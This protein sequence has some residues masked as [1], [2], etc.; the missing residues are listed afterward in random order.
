MGSVD[1]FIE[2]ALS[3]N[4][5][6]ETP[7]NRTMFGQWYGWNGVAWCHIFVS[8][9]AAHSGS[10]DLVPRTAGCEAGWSW[11]RAR[12]QFFRRGVKTPRKGDIVYYG[13]SGGD[14]VG[15]VYAVDGSHIYTIEGNTS[16]S[17]GFNPNGGGV[18]KKKW[19]LNYSRIYGYGRPAFTNDEEVGPDMYVSLG[20]SK[21]TGKPK[22]GESLYLCF[23]KE[24]SDAEHQH[25]DGKAYPTILTAAADYVATVGLAVYGLKDGESCWVRFVEVEKQKNGSFKIT[26]T[27]PTKTI[28][29]R[30]ASG[31]VV[32]D[33]LT[34][35]DTMGKN[36][37]LRIQVGGFP[38][39]GI[40]VHP[41]SLKLHG[42]KK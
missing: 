5:Y 35:A 18:H 13:A 32:Y 27:G 31:S 19:P 1:A 6:L 4:N 39:D 42:W 26:E 37:R 14:H 9:V 34:V 24:Y 30:D 29:N 33:A 23:D 7:V 16:N 3:H 10:A 36:R 20:S 25:G 8:Y 2:E 17:S 40:T 41:T 15:I 38:R 11:F 22:K 28:R 12:G 21:W